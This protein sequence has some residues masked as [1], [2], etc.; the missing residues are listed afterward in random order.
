[1]AEIIIG[2]LTPRNQYTATA[3]QTVFP[4]TFPIFDQDVLVVQHTVDATGITTTLTLTTDYTVTGVDAAGGG[5]VELVSGAASNDIIT[6][7]RDVPVARE[8]DFLTSELSQ[9]I[10]NSMLR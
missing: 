10:K 2:D 1:M 9:S 5:D 6:I 3:A 8:T 7:E 4:Y